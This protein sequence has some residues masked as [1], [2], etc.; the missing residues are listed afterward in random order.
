MSKGSKQRPTDKQKFDD[1]YDQIFKKGRKSDLLNTT[2]KECGIGKYIETSVMDDI[3]GILHC[4]KC[5]S[6]TERHV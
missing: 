6:I 2:C 4:S 5:N 3:N 1:N